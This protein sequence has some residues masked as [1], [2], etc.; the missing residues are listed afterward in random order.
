VA[1]LFVILLTL[2]LT[3]HPVAAQPIERPTDCTETMSGA[4]IFIGHDCGEWASVMIVG[5]IVIRK[6]WSRANRANR[7]VRLRLR[8]EERG[9]AP[10]V[11]SIEP[12]DGNT[13]TVDDIV[14]EVNCD[15]P[16]ERTSITNN[17]PTPITIVE[18]RSTEGGLVSGEA[19]R[20][21][22]DRPLAP[23]DTFVYETGPGADRNSGGMQRQ[24]YDT[25][26]EVGESARVIT[27]AGPP[28]VVPCA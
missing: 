28:I 13:T 26:E 20:P 14:V 6:P 7:G 23:G 24:I 15:S 18:V 16:I 17:G 10:P 25:A 22:P 19:D 4:T 3:P 27:D 5:N 12:G 8:R 21:E 2:E 1:T 9:I 11:T